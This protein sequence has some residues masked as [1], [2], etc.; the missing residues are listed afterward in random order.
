MNLFKKIISQ[1]THRVHLLD[2]DFQKP[3]WSILW[4]QRLLIAAILASALVYEILDTIFP[5][6]LGEIIKQQSVWLLIG[7]LSIY[8]A[9]EISSWFIARP[10]VTQ[11]HSQTIESFRYNAFKTLLAVDP[12]CHS[13]HSSG[14][15]TGK[16]RRTTEAWLKIVKKLM[17]DL[18]PLAFILITTIC[19]LLFFNLTLGLAVGGLLIVLGTTFILS[20]TALTRSIEAKTNRDDDAANHIGNESI[21]RA[22]FIRT[23]F[24]TDQINRQLGLQHL[25]VMRSSSTFFMTHRFMRS[26]FIIC[27][28][29][30]MG[31]TAALLIYLVKAGSIDSILALSLLAMV[32]RSTQPLLK[33]DKY[34]TEAVSAYRKITDC[35]DYIRAYGAQTFPVFAD[36][37]DNEISTLMCST[38]P[39]TITLDH[40]CVTYPDEPPFFSDMTL[41]LAV[42][43][44]AHTKLYGVIGPSGIGK[45]TFFSLLG[46]QFKPSSGT[47]LLN[48]C[49]I[50]RINDSQR[51]RLIAMQGQTTSAMYGSLRENV[52]FGLPEYHGY[53][54]EQ[55]I[56]LLESVGLWYL[57]KE[58]A[59]LDTAIGESGMSL[60]GGQ[61]QRLNFANLFIRAK[62][63]RP[64]VIL[65]D[66]PTSSLDEVSEQKITEMI[67]TLARDSLTLVIAHRIKTL[68]HA[69]KILDFCLV[70]Q[71][72]NLV[73]YDQHELRGK[74]QYFDRLVTGEEPLEE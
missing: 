35:Y 47:V 32:L 74:S 3:W 18:I 44:A 2:I 71:F 53:G 9:Q 64:S 48:G 65:I 33:L 36:Q 4:Q 45:T 13:G 1:P 31:L 51:Q 6:L 58:K 43:R 40:V 59:G 67:M 41:H 14:V 22:G 23:T 50:Y 10:F 24:A 5:I 54:D 49:D 52:L 15:S 66:E 19:S 16:I 25:Q 42:T 73:F 34:V 69:E 28:F 12:D 60:S 8:I 20:V 62:T 72:N 26:V 56:E 61:R 27:Y 11:L 68:E 7:V 29:V 39:I 17:D 21:N 30:G 46:G 63:F 57:F 38:D 55:L 37:S 70:H